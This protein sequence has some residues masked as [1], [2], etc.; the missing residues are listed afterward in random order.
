MYRDISHQLK[1]VDSFSQMSAEQWHKKSK[2]FNPFLLFVRPPIRF[3]EMYLWKLGFLDG[4][5][6]FIIAAS[7]AYYVF[8]KYAKLWEIQKQ[9]ACR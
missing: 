6:G 8:L 2:R 9:E 3:F 5:A 1:T 7:S 4:M